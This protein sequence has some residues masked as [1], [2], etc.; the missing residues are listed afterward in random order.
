MSKTKSSYF[1]VLLLTTRQTF[2][3][4]AVRNF[5]LFAIGQGISLCGTWMQVVAMGWLVLQLTHSGTQLGLVVA[6]QFL[7]ILL[8]GVWGGVIADRFHKRK[9]LYVTQTISGLLAL[10]LGVLVIKGLIETWMVYVISFGFG[11]TMVIDN[12]ARQAFVIEMVGKERVKNAVTINAILVSFGRIV[13]PAIAG[14]TIATFGNGP[15]FLFNAASF[16]AVV[17]A[18]M[19]MRKSELHPTRPVAKEKGQVLAGLRYAWKVKEIRTILIMMLIIGTFAYEFPAVLPLLATKTFGGG[20][21]TY[22]LLTSVMSIGAMAGGVYTA[23]KNKVGMKTIFRITIA[24]GAG[25]LALAAVPSLLLALPMLVF[26]GIYSMMFI[27]TTNAALQLTTSSEM[28]GRVMAML[29]IAFLGTT[30]IGGPIMGYVSTVTSP[31]IGIAVG[32]ASI[33]VAVIIGRLAIGRKKLYA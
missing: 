24:F 14:L 12:P 21:G 29:S 23:G 8:F 20:A 9:I 2:S 5:R 31:R 18:L 22:S 4:L 1:D 32:G 26:V 28:R 17:I 3:S 33:F 7:P 15:C 16:I 6:S 25:M 30:P 11:F 19:F 10:L 27:A 13:G